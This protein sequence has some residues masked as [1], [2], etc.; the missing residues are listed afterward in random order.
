MDPTVVLL[1]KGTL[2][3][4]RDGQQES[5]EVQCRE[6]PSSVRGEEQPQAPAQAGDQPAGKQLCGGGPEGP[7]GREVEREPAVHRCSRAGQQRPGGVGKALSSRSR[8]VIVVLPLC[9]ALGHTP[10][11]LGPVL[12]CPGQETHGHPRASTAWVGDQGTGAC[13][14][15]GE[16]GRLGCSCRGGEG[17]GDLTHVYKYLVGG[18]GLSQLIRAVQ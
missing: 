7:H 17:S 2:A 8:D 16:S 18:S 13:V 3:G 5:C 11:A 14:R 15:G 9:S 10:G 6:M 12:G 1:F 4:W